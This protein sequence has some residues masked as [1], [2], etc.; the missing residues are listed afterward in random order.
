MPEVPRFKPRIESCYKSEALF[1]EKGGDVLIAFHGKEHGPFTIHE[2]HNTQLKLRLNGELNIYFSFH[3]KYFTKSRFTVTVAITIHEGKISHFTLHGEKSADH[4]SRKYPLP[5]SL[6]WCLFF[7]QVSVPCVG[8]K[9]WT[10]QTTGKLQ[11][12]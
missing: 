11:C 8:N 5:P 7:F 6:P 9:S 1:Q 4:E 3:G 2:K 12:S 10:L